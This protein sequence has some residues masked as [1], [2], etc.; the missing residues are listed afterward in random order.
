[1]T[2]KEY[3][4]LDFKNKLDQIEKIVEEMV[5]VADREGLTFVYEGRQYVSKTYAEEAKGLH[6]KL[7]QGWD[8]L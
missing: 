2:S 7:R 4:E 5:R 8:I 3:A 6:F 1:M